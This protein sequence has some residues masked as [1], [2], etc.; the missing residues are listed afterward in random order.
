LGDVMKGGTK[1]PRAPAEMLLC[2]GENDQAVTPRL[3]EGFDNFELL[4]GAGHFVCDTHAHVVADR[5]RSFL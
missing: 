2:I 3:A 1:E 4:P 5:I